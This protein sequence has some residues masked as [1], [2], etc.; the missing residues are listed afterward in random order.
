V[1]ITI[2]KRLRHILTKNLLS[3]QQ[4]GKSRIKLY[5][6]K[7]LY[8]GPLSGTYTFKIF[9]EHLKKNLWWLRQKIFKSCA[10]KKISSSFEHHINIKI[11][12]ML[13]A[14]AGMTKDILA[15]RRKTR[16]G[17]D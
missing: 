17:S 3:A 5:F 13:S 11:D 14:P 2:L 10:L 4:A 8:L 1:N 12:S 7:G 16:S 6:F 9:T 15:A